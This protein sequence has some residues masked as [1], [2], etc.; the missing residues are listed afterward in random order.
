MVPARRGRRAR[1]ALSHAAVHG[2]CLISVYVRMT[3]GEDT[4]FINHV[5]A[6]RACGVSSARGPVSQRS[7][8]FSAPGTGFMEDSFSTDGAGSGKWFR[9]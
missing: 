8:A 9:W 2:V 6:V 4:P 1:G 5:C 7:P 3:R